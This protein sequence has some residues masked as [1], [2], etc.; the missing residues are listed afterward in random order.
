MQWGHIKTLFIL[1]FLILN[2]YLISAFIDRQQDVGYLDNQ[3]LPIEDQLASENITYENIDENVSQLPYISV[4]QHELSEDELEELENVEGQTTEVFNNNLVVSELETAVQ[5]S[6]DMTPEAL[7]AAVQPLVLYG[8][9]YSF[10]EW[11]EEL[12]VLVFFQ[13]KEGRT[14]YY[15]ENGLLLVFLNKDNE[16]THYA[17]TI[18]GESE[19]QGDLVQLNQP[20]QVIGQLFNAN[21]FN[22]GDEVTDAKVGYYSRIAADGVQVF[23][24]T[25][26]IEVNEERN[27]F[28]NAIEGIIY[29][30]DPEEMLLNFISEHLLLRINALEEDNGLRETLLPILERRLELENRSETE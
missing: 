2:I 9:D 7:E 14:I 21:Y 3:E 17:Q 27:H 15:N 1:S 5:I 24:P 8:E 11:N 16:M 18:L 19:V 26:K 25:W 10:W 29:D 20:P 13:E 30:N 6:P 4:I 12:N 23:A 22:R 28:V